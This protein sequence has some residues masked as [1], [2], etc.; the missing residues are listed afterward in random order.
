MNKP[1][2]APNVD[3][4][5]F[6]CVKIL[7]QSGAT[8]AEIEKYTGL[9]H[10]AI[11]R[12]S[13]SETYA[14][15]KNL[16]AAIALEIREK[17]AKKAAEKAAAEKAAAEKAAAEKKPEPEPE[18]APEPEKPAEQPAQVV[19]HRQN[20]TIQATYYVSQKLDRIEELLKTISAKL[21]CIIDDLYGTGPK[22]E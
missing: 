11:Y 2:K 12:I 10:T 6:D 1:K 22:K 4:K 20:I 5:M 18:P 14:D 15:Y 19:E 21:A 17:K 3:Q 16:L 9:G 13:V 8:R 7:L